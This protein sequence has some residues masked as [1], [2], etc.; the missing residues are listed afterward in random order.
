M[1]LSSK[2]DSNLSLLLTLKEEKIATM[3]T[4]YLEDE[5]NDRSEVS[6]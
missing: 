5:T 1:F 2:Y 3:S 6:R 4:L